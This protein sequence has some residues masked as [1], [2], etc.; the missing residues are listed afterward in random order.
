MPLER[1]LALDLGERRI[2][3]AVSDPLGVT[4]QGLA[5]LERRNRRADFDAL[6]GLVEKYN[7]ALILVGHP[8]HLSGRA[9]V[10]AEKAAAFAETLRRKL[11]VTVE[12]WDERLTTREAHRV[13]D[14]GGA[15][16]QQRRKAIDRMSAVLLLQ[17]YLDR[18][19]EAP[20]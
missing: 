11:G 16:L 14:A 3:V 1:I 2:G 18:F 8:L 12:L 19:V 15:T 6:R 5:T 20:K 13:L 7:P 4:A 10:Q 9:G 17:S